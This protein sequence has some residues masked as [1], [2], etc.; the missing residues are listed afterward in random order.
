MIVDNGEVVMVTAEQELLL[1][2]LVQFLD[3]PALRRDTE[4]PV[5]NYKNGA[6]D[7]PSTEEP[8]VPTAPKQFTFRRGDYKTGQLPV[9]ELPTTPA[10][11]MPETPSV[12]Q[13]DGKRPVD[14]PENSYMVSPDKLTS[15]ADMMKETTDQ[16]ETKGPFDWNAMPIAQKVVYLMTGILAAAAVFMLLTLGINFLSG[17]RQYTTKP[18]T[19]SQATS[20]LL[21]AGGSVPTVGAAQ[22]TAAPAVVPPIP[23]ATATICSGIQFY[24][25]P[26]VNDVGPCIASD[27]AVVP[28][29]VYGSDGVWIFMILPNGDSKWAKAADYGYS[30]EQV[31][32]LNLKDYAVVV[33]P[34]PATAAPAWQPSGGPPP[35]AATNAPAPAPTAMPELPTPCATTCE[36]PS[37]RESPPTREPTN[38][39]K[40]NTGSKSTADPNQ[41]VNLSQP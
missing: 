29:G 3:S 18:T 28:T 41:N 32:A 22:P 27:A 24:H 2:G 11:D 30:A 40:S 5:D 21:G 19:A 26:N 9:I 20:S 7:R 39:T 31:K 10:E 35:A 34:P 15:F 6:Q 37:G 8:A 12:V 14:E 16:V 17:G 4:S 38:H 33:A 36:K 13:R 23:A 25:S 1:A